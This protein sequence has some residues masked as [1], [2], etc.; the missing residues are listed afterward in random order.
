MAWP[1]GRRAEIPAR[2]L[3]LI[4][5]PEVKTVF[6][7]RS[8]IINAIRAFLDQRGFVEVD[9]PVLV[10][11][12]AGALARPFATHHHT[13]D[14]D[15]YLRIATELYLKRLIV[16]GFDK[17]YEIG[18]VFRNEGMDQDHNPEFTL[19]ESYEAYADYT[20]VMDMVEE[21]VWTVAESA[22]GTTTVQYRDHTIDLSPPGA[23]PASATP[24][25]N[26]A[27]LSW[28]PT[29]TARNPSKA[30]SPRPDTED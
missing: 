8:R 27:A 3:D 12:A 23:R 30:W 10:P 1:E 2:Y 24:S 26:T 6:V 21:M 17:V 4:S 22:L 5:N 29:S 15:L 18:R 20:Q 14:E 25:E 9:T 11:V 7:Q 28:A 13:L 16:G 19:L